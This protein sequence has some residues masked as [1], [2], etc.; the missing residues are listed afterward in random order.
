M[1]GDHGVDG[2]GGGDELTEVGAVLVAHPTI[3]TDERQRSVWLEEVETQ[4]DEADVDVGSAPHGRADP[5]VGVHHGTG[6]VLQPDVGRVSDHIVR[7]GRSMALEDEV[8]CGDPLGSDDL[9][10]GL[11]N[12]CKQE[13]L[14]RRLASTLCV[15]LEEVKGSDRRSQIGQVAS[16]VAARLDEA[17]DDRPQKGARTARGL[18]EH[19]CAEVLVGCVANE[20]QDHLDDPA[21]REDL[22][23]VGAWIRG[24]L[25]ERQGFLDEGELTGGG[26]KSHLTR[27]CVRS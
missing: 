27:T 3:C 11:G 5:A 15:R 9:G 6:D 21:P 10:L 23:V 8:A 22:A 18:H 24:E 2:V 19:L 17:L 4:L 25:S 20:V 13:L 7:A 12:A 16:V 26:H 1:H 14:G